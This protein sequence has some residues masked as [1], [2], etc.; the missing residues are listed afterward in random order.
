M[1][2]LANF[3][4][5]NGEN[6]GTKIVIIWKTVLHNILLGKEVK[7]LIMGGGGD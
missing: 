4:F 7:W 2:G 6:F 3:K 5:I 1:Y